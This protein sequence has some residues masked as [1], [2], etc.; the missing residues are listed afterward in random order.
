MKPSL[1]QLAVLDWLRRFPAI[2][3][4]RYGLSAAWASKSASEHMLACATDLG[5]FGANAAP[6]LLSERSGMTGSEATPRCTQR[7]T[8]AIRAAGWVDADGHLSTSGREA[9]VQ[10]GARLQGFVPRLA[11]GGDR[12]SNP[13]RPGVGEVKRRGGEA[14]ARRDAEW[15]RSR[16]AD[17]RRIAETIEASLEAY[18]NHK[19]EEQTKWRARAGRGA[20]SR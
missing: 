6:D 9:L 19:S 7:D 12:R 16:E 3:L 4:R 2:T 18:D 20:T 8:E 1:Q 17:H 5:V 14:Q 13:R 15:H 11:C 10:H